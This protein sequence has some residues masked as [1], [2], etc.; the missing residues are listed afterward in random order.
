MVGGKLTRKKESRAKG[1]RGGLDRHR[2]PQ[3]QKDP[4]NREK[5]PS[6]KTQAQK[7]GSS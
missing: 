5:K 4:K 7:P 3:T 1:I 6:L 2:P